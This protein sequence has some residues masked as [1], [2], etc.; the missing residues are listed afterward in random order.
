MPIK[1]VSKICKEL[2]KNRHSGPVR[3]KALAVRPG[4]LNLIPGTP[5]AE[6]D[7]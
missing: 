3:G 5:M 2:L 7:S 6:E 4:H 1:L